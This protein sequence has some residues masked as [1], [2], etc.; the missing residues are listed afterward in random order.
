MKREM[1][2]AT[3]KETNSSGA[4][5]GT[6][7]L[8]PLGRAVD[9]SGA[10][11][12]DGTNDYGVPAAGFYTPGSVPGVCG[13]TFGV[14]MSCG[15]VRGIV[16][17]TGIH[18]RGLQERIADNGWSLSRLRPNGEFC[19]NLDRGYVMVPELEYRRDTRT[20]TYRQHWI[21]FL[22]AFKS[23]AERVEDCLSKSGMDVDQYTPTLAATA[24]PFDKEESQVY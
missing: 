14:S 3:T 7:E 12:Y 2:G 10:Y 19:D 5:T 8:D 13:T 1:Q 23:D 15:I 22:P 21:R 11:N 6:N 4:V 17:G 20:I 9:S 16:R 24:V 18:Q